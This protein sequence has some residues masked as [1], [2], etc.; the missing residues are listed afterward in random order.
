MRRPNLDEIQGLSRDVSLVLDQLYR[1][2]T[3]LTSSLAHRPE[4][5]ELRHRKTRSPRLQELLS[6][7]N[8]LVP[9]L[10]SRLEAIH[11]ENSLRLEAK[12]M[13]DDLHRD[14]EDVMSQHA[15]LLVEIKDDELLSRFEGC[16][17]LSIV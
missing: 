2:L 5:Q 16:V 6:Q 15:A 10:P 17:L 1:E 7:V 8:S 12:V 4:I 3:H 14:L 9:T 11:A 13:L